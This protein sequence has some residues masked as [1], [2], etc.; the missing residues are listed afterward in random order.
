MDLHYS[1][2]EKVVGLF[3]IGIALLLLTTVVMIGRGKDWFKKYVDYTTVFQESY[4]IQSNTPVKLYKTDI[5]KVDAVTLVGDRVEVQLAI[6]EEYAARITR[7][8][9]VTIESPTL[10]GSEYVS[11]VPGP[12]SSPAIEP[13]GLIPSKPRRSLSDVLA[14][15]E[16]EKTARR[17]AAIVKNIEAVT[18]RLA[19]PEGPLWTTLDHVERTT[20][21]LSR[22]AGDIERG[23]GTVGRLLRSAD[24]I[25]QIEARVV[26]LDEVIDPLA[27]A[28]RQAPPAMSLVKENLA[29]LR[30]IQAR[31]APAIE[32]VRT[33]LDQTDAAME[34][35][36]RILKQIEAASIHAPPA[37]QSARDT[38]ERVAENMEEIEQIIEAVR[39][40]F[41]IRPH[42]PPVPAPEP[43]D[44]GIRP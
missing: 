18:D 1:K 11:I 35:L 4:G 38:L 26:K 19:D 17:L 42:L 41:L 2:T 36:H 10:I 8:T 16:V 34:S 27:A 30:R 25:E 28:A 31:V 14:E 12:V 13:G 24:M 5:G 39:Q 40:N 37:A 7:G 3:L 22:V 15:M 33:V 44:S 20:G 9:R 32:Q 6:Q 21:S 23:Q 29:D 43:L